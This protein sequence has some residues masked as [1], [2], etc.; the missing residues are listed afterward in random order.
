MGLIIKGIL[1]GIGKILP[2][3]SGAMIAISIG[4]YDKIIENI[5]NIK[6]EPIKKLSYLSKIGTGIIIAIII[7]SKVIVKCLS[8][9]YFITMLLFLT[10]I[11]YSM[12]EQFKNI[13]SKK[14]DIKNMI[15][16]II[17]IVI[18]EA[19]INNIKLA[20][21]MEIE[22]NIVQFVKLL[23]IGVIDAASSIIPGLSGTALLMMLGY[24]NIIIKTFS[25]ILELAQVRPNIFIMIPFIIGFALGVFVIARLLDKIS[26][27]HPHTLN[28][29]IMS[30][31][32]CSIFEIIKRI[33]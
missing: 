33:I 9:Y 23:G 32:I 30:L 16:V 20:E 8:K 10:A 2:G 27:K 25:N 14:K 7:I 22:Y 11:L 24:Y 5:A 28:L 3:V 21:K 19:T 1:I 26:K 13:K 12:K 6:E 29:I 31:M 17:I 15:V 4:E 18:L